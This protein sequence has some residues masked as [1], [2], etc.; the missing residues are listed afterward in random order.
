MASEL[1]KWVRK[2]GDLGY[3]G[4]VTPDTTPGVGMWDNALL[5]GSLVLAL[6]MPSYNTPYYGT[7][8]FDG[9]AATH[10]WA[11]WP[12]Y[13]ESWKDVLVT[14]T[15]NSNPTHVARLHTHPNRR[16]MF[17]W[18]D[19]GL[20]KSNGYWD[21]RLGYYGFPLMGHCMQI[22][23]NVMKIRFNTSFPYLEH[24][25]QR[26]NDG[27]MVGLKINSADDSIH[28][29][30]A[31][32]CLVNERFPDLAAAAWTNI[33]T[34][35]F[36]NGDSCYDSGYFLWNAWVNATPALVWY[37]PN[38]RTDM[39]PVHDKTGYT[40][41]LPSP[42]LCAQPCRGRLTNSWS[43]DIEIFTV[44]N[45]RLIALKPGVSAALASGVYCI[46][47]SDGKYLDK[48]VVLAP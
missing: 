3:G 38:W 26:A 20:I 42:L 16:E 19:G 33:D 31:Q 25:F 1:N 36:K 6:A 39:S 11:P 46:R 5:M 14:Y 9:T 15:D 48:L 13:A 29:A 23:A 7:S 18:W 17:N 37:N 10:L 28:Q 24:A 45:E 4:G 40:P 41:F 44:R 35:L 21:N 12:D 30:F 47:S 27:T 22:F 43:Q 32:V 2:W 34:R 8:G